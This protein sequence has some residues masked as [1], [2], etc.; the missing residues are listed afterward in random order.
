MQARGAC[1]WTEE[2]AICYAGLHLDGKAAQWF[3]N[4]RFTRWEPFQKAF[5]G[6]FGVDPSKVLSTLSKRVQGRQEPVRDY[7]EA[8][9]TLARYST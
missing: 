7:A 9:R 4:S 3:C 1:G 8:L 6:R 2:Q 5:L